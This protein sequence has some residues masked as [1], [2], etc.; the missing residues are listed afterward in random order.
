MSITGLLTIGRVSQL[1]AC[2]LCI[3]EIPTIVVINCSPHPT[4]AHLHPPLHLT[5]PIHESDGT[6]SAGGWNWN[7][8]QHTIP[9]LQRK[10][11]TRI[12]IY[13]TVTH[14]SIWCL[15]H[16]GESNLQSWTLAPGCSYS[17]LVLLVIHYRWCCAARFFQYQH[18]IHANQMELPLNMET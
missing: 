3:I 15:H 2:D 18:Q 1:L 4:S 9:K 5:P 16:N 6:S 13:V 17:L 7:E 12:C 10:L 8:P 14:H 11:M